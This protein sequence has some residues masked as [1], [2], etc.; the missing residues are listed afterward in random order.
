MTVEKPP[1]RIL[2]I[3]TSCDETAASVIEGGW[4]ILSNAVASQEDLHAQYGGI[5]PEIALCIRDFHLLW[6]NRP[7][8]RR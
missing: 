5:F 3:E 7:F 8:E 4:I 6:T 2:A 1:A